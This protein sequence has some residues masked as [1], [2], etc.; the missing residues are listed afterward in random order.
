MIEYNTDKNTIL[1][2]AQQ[3]CDK[4]ILKRKPDLKVAYR[5]NIP[6]KQLIFTAEH[7]PTATI[8]ADAFNNHDFIAEGNNYLGTVTVDADVDT[9]LIEIIEECF[10]EDPEDIEPEEP[11]E[12]DDEHTGDD[13]P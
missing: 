10:P 1:E 11:E 4:G 2:I 9:M 12:P 8:I 7:N 5:V 6:S 13:D 3:L